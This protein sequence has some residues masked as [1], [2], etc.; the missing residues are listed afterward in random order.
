MRALAVGLLAAALLVPARARAD[1]C[2]GNN[3]DTC[4]C[5]G[6]D[7]YPCCDNGGN[8]TW[9]AWEE[10]CCNWHRAL[11]MWGNA[12]DWAGNARVDGYNVS[13]A[14][15][16]GTIANEH[17]GYNA[18]SGR[19]SE[20]G[21]VAWVD[22]LTGGGVHV[23]E[24]N[25]CAGCRGSAIPDWYRA[26]YFNNGYIGL[27]GQRE[28]NPGDQQVQGCGNCGT[29]SRSCDS[30]GNW[31]GWSGCGGSGPCSPGQG[32]TQGCGNC[33]SQQRSCGGNCQWS[34]WGSCN[35]QGECA[36]GQVQQQACCDCGT[37]QRVCDGA[38]RWGAMSQC[39]GPDP[40]GTPACS[41]GK[42]GVC[43]AGTEHCVGGC[44]A[45][46]QTTQASPEKCD[47]LDDDCN[48]KVDDGSPTTMGNPPPAFAA[49]IVDASY[50]RWL[51]AGVTS[52][53][54]VEIEN[55]GASTWKAG[56]VSLH[57]DATD[58][59]KPSLLEP[60]DGWPAYDTAAVLDQ[61]V[62]PGDVAVL[63]FPIRTASSQ[64]DIDESFTLSNPTGQ[65]MD[66]PDA[67]LPVSIAT[68]GFSSATDPPA[69]APSSAAKTP[70]GCASARGGA[71]A[72]LL[73]LA[74]FGLRRRRAT[75]RLP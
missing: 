29:Q 26:C 11:P 12:T 56:A 28:C 54:W 63:R 13:G 20:Y 39:A 19:Y 47:G 62:A 14:P 66:C 7:P 33:G 36:P 50:P 42:L 35:G 9:W 46:V 55:V 61:D 1:Y 60:P 44:L 71:W 30:N 31:G 5:A 68:V 41:T 57:A 16:V 40:A 21:H 75:D 65:S 58:A 22:G 52:E 70:S 15:S 32:Q 23:M 48:G 24:Q 38:C 25:C 53:A 59:G 2:C 43:A 27:P 10:A 6:N 8:C 45:C 37:Q 72:L 18:C 67:T 34:G 4:Q 69:A 73:A 51:A 3:C 74:L 49:A 64:A 17:D